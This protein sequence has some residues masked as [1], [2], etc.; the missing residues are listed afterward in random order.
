MNIAIAGSTGFIGSR[1]L[2]ALK[3]NPAY[4]IK[5][6]TRRSDADLNQTHINPDDNMAFVQ[7]DSYVLKEL[8][9]VLT[10]CD[11]LIYLIHSM[12]PSATLMQGG[13]WDFD[14]YLADNYAKAARA[15][16]LKQI[17]YLGG[18]VPQD[19]SNMSRHL[20]SR[21]EVE[22]ILQASGVPCTIFRAGLII[23]VGGSSFRILE[24]LVRRLPLMVCPSWT[25]VKS[26]AI[27]VNDLLMAVEQVLGQPHYFNKT[28]D[29][30][31]PSPISY[32][33]MILLTAKVMGKNPRLI[34]VPFLTP[35]LSQLWV[36]MVS[37]VPRA[38]VYPL[39]ESMR[40]E[41]L[42]DPERLFPFQRP[43]RSF[44]Q[45]VIDAI[46]PE[47]PHRFSLRKLFALRSAFRIHKDVRSIQ[48]LIV[49]IGWGAEQVA[50]AY[51]KWLPTF[52]AT[53]IRTVRDQ[54]TIRIRLFRCL[55]L[56]QLEYQS[57]LSDD[58]AAFFSVTAGS[59]VKK[60][61]YPKG[62]LEFREIFN[63][64]FVL[65]HLQDFRPTLPWFFYKWTQ[66]QMH[67]FVIN[68]FQ[69]ELLRIRHLTTEIQGQ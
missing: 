26:Q 31:G 20:H 66:A 5:A 22:Q 12:L 59:L 27:D 11:V 32:R 67:L 16:G 65:C 3:T 68:R 42:V 55:T 63:G 29:I 36:R 61:I 10:G 45:S 4:R 23:G 19:T 43:P 57:D 14:A 49:P 51:M 35:R 38:L 8:V 13:F 48:R 17:I 58:T 69:T 53:A 46:D 1:V 24:R 62:R 7:V 28:F 33:Q 30:A 39:I 21:R 64:S 25:N 6:L 41:L 60:P 40:H 52:F 54:N 15:C 18:L 2:A 47:R 9:E 37:G 44:E 50:R 56:I 34:N